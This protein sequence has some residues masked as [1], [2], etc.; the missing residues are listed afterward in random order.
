MPDSQ[1][2]EDEALRMLSAMLRLRCGFDKP[3]GP[4][5]KPQSAGKEPVVAKNILAGMNVL[6]KAK[7]S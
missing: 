5:R 6:P 2:N 4:V 3:V 7:K 1:D